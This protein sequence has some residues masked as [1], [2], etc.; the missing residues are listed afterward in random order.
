MRGNPAGMNCCG[1]VCTLNAN[2]QRAS[3]ASENC[4]SLKAVIRY[5]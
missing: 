5:T 3:F 4:I 1:T 2:K